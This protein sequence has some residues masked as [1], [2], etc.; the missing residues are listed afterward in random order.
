LPFVSGF[1][2]KGKAPKK[3]NLRFT[4][5]CA[6]PVNDSIMETEGLVRG[7]VS[8]IAEHHCFVGLYLDRT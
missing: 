8:C 5:D 3:P 1:Q 6:D 4:I 2:R 7:N